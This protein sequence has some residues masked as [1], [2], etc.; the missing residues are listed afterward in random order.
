M[1]ER[2][3]PPSN[4][5]AL[6]ISGPSLVQTG[7]AAVWRVE[8]RDSLGQPV[9]DFG[10]FAQLGHGAGRPYRGV[11]D[12]AGAVEFEFTFTAPSPSI[13]VQFTTATRA[14]SPGDRFPDRNGRESVTCTVIAADVKEASLSGLHSVPALR[15]GGAEPIQD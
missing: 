8:V 6:T 1:D 3:E 15:G 10:V 5:M 4:P 2:I 12:A 11:T 14:F 13:E 7:Q 9:P